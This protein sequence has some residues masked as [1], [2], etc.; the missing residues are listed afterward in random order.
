MLNIERYLEG[1]NKFMLNKNSIIWTIGKTLFHMM[2]YSFKEFVNEKREFVKYP[3]A[4]EEL[5]NNK[6]LKDTHMGERCF[7]LGNGP[8]LMSLDFEALS[9]EVTFTFNQLTRN[10]N[11]A[12]LKTNYHFWSD[13]KFYFLDASKPEDMELLNVMKAVNTEGNSPVAFYT[14]PAHDPLVEK[15][16]LTQELD[17]YYYSNNGS[18]VGD[19]VKQEL[20]PYRPFPQMPTTVH[21]AVCFAVY[22]GFKEIYLLGCDCSGFMNVMSAKLKSSEISLYAYEISDNEKKRMEAVAN[23]YTT[24]QELISA[25]GVFAK[26]SY[27]KRY[28][29]ARGVKLFNATDGGLLDSLPRIDVKEVLA[30]PKPGRPI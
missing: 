30:Q 16:G 25:I 10:P 27:L 29:D 28:C 11:F 24:E 13:D 5:K 22:M 6:H 14:L 26:Y 2:P 23:K 20:S 18:E 15:Y 21:Y 4:K 1:V 12:K 8:S 3:W 7:I 9:E 19:S 17:I